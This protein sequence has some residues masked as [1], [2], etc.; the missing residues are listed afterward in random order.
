M[1]CEK[2]LLQKAKEQIF[3]GLSA[4]K[5]SRLKVRS[6]PSLEEKK[7]LLKKSAL[8]SNCVNFAEFIIIIREK[9]QN[10]VYLPSKFKIKIFFV[11]L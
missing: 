10:V 5:K 8:I 6:L 11:K 1:C 2:N 9:I 4:F 7:T 3:S